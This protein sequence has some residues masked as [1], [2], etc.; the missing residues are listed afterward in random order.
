MTNI[1]IITEEIY[2]D[3]QNKVTLLILDLRSLENY[4]AGHING[5]TNAK[6]NNMQQKQV[7]MSKLPKDQ[8][9]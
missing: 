3:I 4:M 8:T 6:C 5:S 7:I 2:E 1:E 9:Q